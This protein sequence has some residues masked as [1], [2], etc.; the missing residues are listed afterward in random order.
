MSLLEALLSNM[1]VLAIVDLAQS[2]GVSSSVFS[3]RVPVNL[4]WFSS[5][6]LGHIGGAKESFMIMFL[7]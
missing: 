5:L 6:P 7:S 1:P 3:S 4:R 2:V